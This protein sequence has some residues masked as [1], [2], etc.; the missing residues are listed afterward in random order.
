ME[1]SLELF[2]LALIDSG[3]STPYEFHSR[4]GI[5]VGASLP[6]LKKLLQQ[7]LVSRGK[8]GD[9]RRMQYSLTA[10]G[11]A[12]LNKSELRPKE[13]VEEDIAS[14]LRVAILS[15][16]LGSRAQAMKTLDKT[17]GLLSASTRLRVPPDLNSPAAA[18]RWMLSIC[19]RHRRKAEIAALTEI[20]QT[21]KR[22][23]VKSASIAVPKGLL[24]V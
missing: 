10:G 24:G 9:R 16:Y 19:D 6:A 1:S 22:E 12:A 20:L 3:L 8:A 14:S 23:R 2:L 5:S 18:Y 21:M 15:D 7:R 17:R 11:R 4:A 13:D